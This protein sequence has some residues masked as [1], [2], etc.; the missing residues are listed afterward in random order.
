MKDISL[1]LMDIVQNSIAADATL[2]EISVAIDGGADELRVS[3]SDNGKGMDETLLKR[4]ESPFSTTRTT[5]KVGLGIPLFKAGA[6]LTG[7]SFD[8]RSTPGKGTTVVAIYGFSH[9]DRPPLG[10]VA[11]TVHMIIAC[12]PETDICFNA[13]Y[14]A[15]AYTLD[16][17]EIKQVLDGVP[18][19]DPGVLQ[20]IQQA[21]A[22]GLQETFGGVV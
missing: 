4:V 15:S 9:I 18:I 12:N 20:W 14:G 10:D 21:L 1:H 3:I 16:T 19:N 22:E 8:I 6:L 7:G 17:R 5:R 13:T 11:G 2:V